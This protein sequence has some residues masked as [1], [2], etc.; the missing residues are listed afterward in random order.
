M[1]D[2][3]FENILTPILEHIFSFYS[4]DD[5]QGNIY[6]SRKERV[7]TTGNMIIH[8]YSNDHD[9]PHFHVFS[10]DNK[11]NAKFTIESCELISGNISSRDLKKIV[12]FYNHPKVLLAMQAI[13][14]KRK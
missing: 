3:L 6:L 10:R 14:N 4:D 5:S 9:P 2:K 12:T 8:I 1:S 13:W 11:I 7:G